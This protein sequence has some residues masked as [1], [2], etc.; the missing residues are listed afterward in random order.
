MESE[1]KFCTKS[2]LIAI[3]FMVSMFYFTIKVDDYQFIKDFKDTLNEQQ[4]EKYNN[5][6]TE[7]LGIYLRGYFLGLTISL[8][9]ILLKYFNDDAITTLEAVCLTL[10]SSYFCSYFY[11]ILHKKSDYMI[12]HLEKQ[13]QREEW[14]NVYTTMQKNYHLG[15]LFGLL[16]VGFL[17]FS[18]C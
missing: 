9:F 18:V 11:Y 10:S 2:C 15:L 5:I 4:L 6:K 8:V 1:K 16:A 7:R 14:L 3:F 13:N 12:L 17:T